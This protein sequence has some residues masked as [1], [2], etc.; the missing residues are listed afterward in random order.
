[1]VG[2]GKEDLG[3]RYL[4]TLIEH[5]QHLIGTATDTPI[6]LKQIGVSA[7]VRHHMGIPDLVEHGRRLLEFS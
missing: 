2:H 4:N 5:F 6:D 1:M 3:I 7:E